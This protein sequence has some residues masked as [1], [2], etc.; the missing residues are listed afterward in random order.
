MKLPL[1]TLA[2]EKKWK[3]FKSDLTAKLLPQ[4][5]PHDFKTAVRMWFSWLWVGAQRFETGVQPAIQRRD[6]KCA[7]WWQRQIFV[8]IF[9]A[10]S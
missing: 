9:Y 6:G 7:I 3:V 5:V 1:K 10:I 8:N 2:V 4:P